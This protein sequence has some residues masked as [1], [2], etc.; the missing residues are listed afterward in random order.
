[1]PSSRRQRQNSAV[2][3]SMDRA[4][5]FPVSS[6]SRGQTSSCCQAASSRAETADWGLWNGVERDGE[7]TLAAAQRYAR[8][9]A[10]STGPAALTITKRQIADDPPAARPS[11]VGRRLPPSARR[12]DE[13][14]RIL[15]RGTS[16]HREA[17]AELLIRERRGPT[18][19][20]NEPPGDP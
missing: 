12:G 11:G 20:P 18:R 19:S 9:L 6:A 10:E 4:G 13:P 16:P 15:R 7:A 3:P 1:M 14:R 2:P 17:P 8:M 5:C